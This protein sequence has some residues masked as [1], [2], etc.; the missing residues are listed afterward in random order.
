MKKTCFP[1]QPANSQLSVPYCT[2][3][4]TWDLS[5]KNQH[6]LKKCL[7]QANA[8]HCVVLPTC[9]HKAE[10]RPAVLQEVQRTLTKRL[11]QRAL[12]RR[13]HGTPGHRLPGESATPS[14]CS[15]TIPSGG[16]AHF[17]VSHRRFKSGW[18]A[19]AAGSET[20]PSLIDVASDVVG[21]STSE[22]S[23]FWL[24]FRLAAPRGAA[25]ALAPRASLRV[26]PRLRSR[27]A[28]LSL[29]CGSVMVPV[30]WDDCC[31]CCRPVGTSRMRG[32]VRTPARASCATIPT[33]TSSC[34]TR[35]EN[36]TSGPLASRVAHVRSFKSLQ[37][38]ELS[39][40]SYC[41]KLTLVGA[42]G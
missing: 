39:K 21:L 18:A 25:S 26:L 27:N 41:F 20:K 23:E 1:R 38:F 8:F 32:C 35:T 22:T 31:L 17:S 9:S 42:A 11:L 29:V 13:L 6:W 40:T 2:Q 4:F 28:V 37:G 5:F 24:I 36:T 19:T 30:N 12:C 33:C 16:S 14:S 7:L 10:L 15:D 3:Y 34:P